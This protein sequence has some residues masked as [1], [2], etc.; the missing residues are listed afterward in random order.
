MQLK[1]EIICTRVGQVIRL[2]NDIHYSET[3][4]YLCP[5]SFLSY[6]FSIYFFFIPSLILLYVSLFFLSSLCIFNVSYSFFVS[7]LLSLSLIV[8]FSSIL[9]VFF[10]LL[11]YSNKIFLSY[12]L[13]FSFLFLFASLYFFLFFCLFLSYIIFIFQGGCN[14]YNAALRNRSTRVRTLV[15]LLRSLGKDMNPLILPSMH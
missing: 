13:L 2:W 12:L 8:F 3:L 10:F 11:T 14:G 6:R 15:A 4:K 7:S 5:P 1:F 9:L